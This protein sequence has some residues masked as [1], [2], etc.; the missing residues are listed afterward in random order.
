MLPVVAKM[1]INVPVFG[2]VKDNKH[3]TRAIA[4]DGGEIEINSHRGA[5][6]LV[7]NI[8]E[9]VHRFAITYHHNKH[10]K[11]AFS[12]SLLGSVLTCQ[13]KTRRCRIGPLFHH[14]RS[15]NPRNGSPN[16]AYRSLWISICRNLWISFRMKQFYCKRP[17]DLSRCYK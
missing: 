3:R 4:F 16:S 13:G 7:S 10:K 15:I 11:S 17:A 1:G 5:F 14:P 8:Q 2:M 12:S 9:E 6:T